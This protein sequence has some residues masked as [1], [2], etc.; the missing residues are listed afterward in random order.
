LKLS[1]LLDLSSGVGAGEAFLEIRH[2]FDFALQSGTGA[3]AG[4]GPGDGF[5]GGNQ[6]CGALGTVT[7]ECPWCQLLVP[8]SGYPDRLPC[9]ARYQFENG[10]TGRNSGWVTSR[11]D[12]SPYIGTRQDI[13][14]AIWRD[15]LPSTAQGW[16]IDE[17]RVISLVSPVLATFGAG[18]LES[19]SITPT[20]TGVTCDGARVEIAGR[21]VFGNAAGAG[22]S[23]DVT[24]SAG[25]FRSSQSAAHTVALSAGGRAEVVVEHAAETAP[26]LTAVAGTIQATASIPFG[27]PAAAE[28]CGDGIDNDCAN[29]VDDGC[30]ILYDVESGAEGWVHGLDANSWCHTDRWSI[31]SGTSVSGRQS[32]SSGASQFCEG[33]SSLVSPEFELIGPQ[34]TLRFQHRHEFSDCPFGGTVADGARVEISLDGA[35]FVPIAPTTGYPGVITRS[36]G[37]P[38]EGQSVFVED[39]AMFQPVEFDLAPYVGHAV[40]FRMRAA[41]DCNLCRSPSGWYIDDIVV[42]GRLT[43]ADPYDGGVSSGPDR[44]VI[45]DVPGWDSGPLPIYD[46]TVRD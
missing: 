19:V 38:L 46:A 39:L 21:D 4:V 44:F 26:T 2:R 9:N 32:W 12:V 6:A 34:P 30:A 7:V 16:W 18:P 23:V 37:N 5:G 11:F 28:T 17:V 22:A 40:R 13:V 20:T 8:E 43:G 33:S 36:C 25:Q 24:L 3:D 35:G 15:A 42:P 27:P 29:G 41:N 10:F 45:R 1:F 31:V 14:F